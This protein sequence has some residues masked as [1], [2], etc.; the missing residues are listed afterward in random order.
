MTSTI[1]DRVFGESSGVALKAPV[2]V[3]STSVLASLSGLPIV[4]GY[5]LIEGDRI[6]VAGQADAT[7][8]GIY[9]A[10]A[11][12]AT[13]P[14]VGDFDGTNDV[15]QG[16]L[17]LAQ[18]PSPMLYQL[19]TA[20]PVIGTSDLI[21]SVFQATGATRQSIGLLL[22]PQ[23]SVEASGGLTPTDYARP[24]DIYIDPRRY[25]ADP[26]GVS[27][28]TAA[29]QAAINTAY[30]LKGCVYIGQGC[31]F[32]CGSLSLT[33]T[34]NHAT[35]G[36]RIVGSSVN[37]SKL[38]CIGAPATFIT[39]TG[40]TPT[41]APQEAPLVMENLTL[42]GTT[43]S[44]G[45]L[46]Q[47]VAYW[48][49]RNVFIIG[50]DKNLYLNSALTGAIEDCLLYGGNY[51]LYART[52]GAGAQSNLL[53]VKHGVIAANATW[54]VDYDGGSMLLLDGCDIEG[55][56]TAGNYATG[57]VH[58]G[59]NINNTLGFS[60]IDLNRLWF[61][62]NHGSTILVDAPLSGSSWIR[63]SSVQTLTEDSGHAITVAGAAHLTIDNCWSPTSGADWNLTADYLKVT[64]S[65]V[66]NA[67]TISATYKVYENFATSTALYLTAPQN[68]APYKYVGDTAAVAS[69]TP[70]TLQ[71]LPA[72][73][74]TYL[75]STG[76]IGV[77]ASFY[78]TVA[79]VSVALDG[80]AAIATLL[81]G[82]HLTLALSGLDV[83]AT[84][85]SGGS[86]PI[87]F[88]IMQIA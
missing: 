79:V 41:G 52:D 12:Q 10:T 63:L 84:Q 54:G 4:D 51:G 13:W 3:A 26:T 60:L 9:T 31:N 77:T 55:N 37:G 16:T 42:S 14:R 69:G 72:K 85:S 48:T 65:L 81:A 46:L 21:F 15:V 59:E 27:D 38:T 80:S 22:N 86:Q 56:G 57:G 35:D 40:S 73:N 6:L 30:L 25:G 7:Q 64:N 50:F 29:V 32:L 2:Q 17:V 45:L 78:N 5:Q 68:F 70:I 62:S 23:L 88:S 82:S 34:G 39:F 83:Q 19:T 1:T 28:S 43:A 67:P 49:L 24:T 44:V 8:N 36:L 47:G 75:V 20:D 61:E 58:I 53:R 66:F 33:F 76:L 18:N 74:A 87:S 11:L 71:T